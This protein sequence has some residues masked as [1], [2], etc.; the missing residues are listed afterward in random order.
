[1]PTINKSQLNKFKT[2]QSEWLNETLFCGTYEKRQ[3]EKIK[4]FSA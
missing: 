4:A 1:M 2:E 3:K